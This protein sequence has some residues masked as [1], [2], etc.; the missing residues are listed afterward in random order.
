MNPRPLAPHASALAGLRHAP[1][2]GEIIAAIRFSGNVGYSEPRKRPP[3]RRVLP[4]PDR[5]PVPA[6]GALANCVSTGRQDRREERGQA[7]AKGKMDLRGLSGLRGSKNQT[8][9]NPVCP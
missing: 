3:T 1:I 8:G 7:N 4:W 6:S 2:A 9:F 5:P